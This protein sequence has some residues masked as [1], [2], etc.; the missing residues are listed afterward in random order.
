M[1]WVLEFIEIFTRPGTSVEDQT[2]LI[3]DISRRR[4]PLE[5]IVQVE[6]GPRLQLSLDDLRY[7]WDTSG[8]SYE[9]RALAWDNRTPICT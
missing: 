6:R 1:E 9:E 2:S 4:I 7:V 8:L 5:K 3:D